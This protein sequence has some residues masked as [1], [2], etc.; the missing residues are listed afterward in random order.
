MALFSGAV[1]DALYRIKAGARHWVVND[2]HLVGITRVS[3]VGFLPGASQ[4]V[5][6]LIDTEYGPLTLVSAIQPPGVEGAADPDCGLAAILRMEHGLLAVRVDEFP[7][8]PSRFHRGGHARLEGVRE[9]SLHDHVKRL[10]ADFTHAR[11]IKEESGFSEPKRAPKQTYLL[12]SSA[13]YW[14]ALKAGSVLRAGRRQGLSAVRPP[15]GS[16]MIAQMDG[17]ALAA[18]SLAQMHGHAGADE[19]WCLPLSAEHG[20]H[21]LLVETI[22][23]LVDVDASQVKSLNLNGRHA[24]WLILPGRNPVEVLFEGDC[25]KL[26]SSA[27][28]ETQ[29]SAARGA[30][31][32]PKRNALRLKVGSLDLV[33]PAQM[34]GPVVGPLEARAA[35]KKSTQQDLAVW[36]LAQLMGLRSRR[37]A[38]FGVVIKLA[39]RHVV[40]LCDNAEMTTRNAVGAAPCMPATIGRLIEGIRLVDGVSELQVNPHASVADIKRLSK[41]NLKQAHKGWLNVS[42]QPS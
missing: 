30:P 23:G 7:Q 14:A 15:H 19:P 42:F 39:D 24:S 31:S 21:A 18:Q 36:D 37:P 8:A 41:N 4:A 12:V 17:E 33:V 13:G 16:C 11:R 2:K 34:L 27:S 26:A 6:G 22:A 10:T 20:P 32:M 29:G 5:L 28:E 38:N 25:D 40:A 9:D 3:G 35:Q 1:D